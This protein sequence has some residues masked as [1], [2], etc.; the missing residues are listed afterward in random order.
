MDRAVQGSR[1]D[2]SVFANVSE[3]IQMEVQKKSPW[4][5]CA[6]PATINWFASLSLAMTGV[7]DRVALGQRI[8][9]TDDEVASREARGPPWLAV[10]SEPLSI[11]IGF[12]NRRSGG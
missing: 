2:M 10:C 5:D 1:S 3:A 11:G 12:T 6:S 9:S 4:I 7:V 8:F